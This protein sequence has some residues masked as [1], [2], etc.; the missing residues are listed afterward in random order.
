MTLIVALIY[1]AFALPAVPLIRGWRAIAKHRPG[2]ITT[3]ANGII[4]ASYIC[5]VA[6][7]VGAAVIAPHYTAARNHTI[8]LNVAAILIA[9]ILVVRSRSR[10]QPLLAGCGTIGLWLY[11]GV[12]GSV[13]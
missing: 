8:E 7:V 10:R 11:L 12:V 2:A 3:I 6:V 13:V 4:T 9:I 5:V 1:V